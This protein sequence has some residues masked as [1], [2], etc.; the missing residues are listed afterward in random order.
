[1]NNL[2]KGLDEEILGLASIAYSSSSS[3]FEYS[4][5]AEKNS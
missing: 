2:A 1:V 3:G 5:F 4:C